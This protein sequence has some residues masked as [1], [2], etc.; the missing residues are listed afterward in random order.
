MIAALFMPLA[1]LARYTQWYRHGVV[2][3][4]SVLAVLVGLW[5]LLQRLF[6]VRLEG[7]W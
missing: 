1:W 3:P 7:L 2:V 6:N 5:W 4:G